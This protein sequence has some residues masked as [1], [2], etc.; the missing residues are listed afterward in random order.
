[1]TA[2]AALP[3]SRQRLPSVSEVS[4]VSSAQNRREVNRLE[5]N[6]SH[7]TR[8]TATVRLHLSPTE[9]QSSPQ[10]KRTEK[11][12]TRPDANDEQ[13]G[14][15]LWRAAERATNWALQG[16]VT[17]QS[18]FGNFLLADSFLL[19]SWATVYSG[20]VASGSARTAVLATLA[21]VS[22]LLG[23]AFAL[24]GSRYAKYVHLQWELATQ[25]E[26]KLPKRFRFGERVDELRHH[27]P[28]TVVDGGRTYQLSTV[29][30][31]VSISRLLVWAPAALCVT[32]FVLLTISFLPR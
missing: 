28:V 13:G 25:A 17:V 4:A 16:E 3:L 5:L 23:A 7:P 32:S 15:L 22:V 9:V 2:Q 11:V 18:R 8:R 27:K 19:L 14:E 20:S 21:I 30:R 24:L 26:R 1:M 31:W 10:S 12:T 6:S 29:E